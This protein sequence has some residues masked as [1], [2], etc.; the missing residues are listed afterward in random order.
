MLFR[1]SSSRWW[2]VLYAL[3]VV[4]VLGRF[5]NAIVS[6][7]FWRELIK[8]EPLGNTSS[9]GEWIGEI[10]EGFLEDF[11]VFIVIR[12]LIRKSGNPSP[13]SPSIPT[14]DESV[15]NLPSL[16]KMSPKAFNILFPFRSKYRELGLSKWWWHRLAIV[17]FAVALSATLLMGVWIVADDYGQKDVQLNRASSEYFD[18]TTQT[19]QNV[20]PTA[21]QAFNKYEE[22][23]K[24]I[25]HDAAVT[26]WSEI[27]YTLVFLAGLSYILQ[28]L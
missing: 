17:L 3:A 9:V 23:Y 4:I 11:V 8:I 25:T 24:R 5:G 7:H 13:P 1:S 15:S 20:T 2:I 10:G 18:T 28:L 6:N 16:P 21:S 22:Q 14:N 26:L 27:G 19:D 12:R